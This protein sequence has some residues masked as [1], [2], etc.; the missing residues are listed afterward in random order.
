MK[1]EKFK[2]VL[3]NESFLVFNILN[4]SRMKKY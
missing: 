4:K 1:N 3:V 2:K